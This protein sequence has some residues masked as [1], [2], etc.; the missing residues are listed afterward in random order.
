[1]RDRA[2]LMTSYVLSSHL[3]DPAAARGQAIMALGQTIEKQSFIANYS[4]TFA[5]LGAMLILAICLVILTRNGKR[6]RGP[7]LALASLFHRLIIFKPH[8]FAR[9]AAVLAALLVASS[10]SAAPV[11]S[12]LGTWSTAN[13]HGVVE[14]TQCGDALC[15]RIVGIDRK[16]TEPMP[17]DVSGRPQCGLTIITNE[18]AGANGIWLGEVTDPRDGDTYRAML[19]LDGDGDLRLRGFIGIPQ[20]GATQ[21]WHRF[22]GH[23]TAECGLA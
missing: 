23:L 8:L 15:G 2:Q 10:A 5:A 14:I 17:T 22:T 20:L 6:L 3:S 4:T 11:A 21:V 9:Y 1:M 7:T 18:R 13:G 12:L 19:W 16:P